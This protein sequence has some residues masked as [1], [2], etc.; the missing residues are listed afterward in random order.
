M[1]AE[2][3]E[4]LKNLP[5]SPGV[6]LMKDKSGDIIYVG[7][8]KSL[9]SR[10][11]SYFR[12]GNHTYKTSIM[13]EYINDFEYIVTD[14]EVEAYILE[15]NLIK[16]YSP[17]FNIRLKD[18]KSYP[19]IKIT[20]N[21]DFP[22]IF[23]SR[24][25]KKDG[26]KYFGPYADVDA[27]YKSI[28]I[29]KDIFKLRTCKKEIIAGKPEARPCLNFY[30]D[31]C[32][33]PCIGAISQG[34]YQK[35]VDLIAD[36]LA[37]QQD[38]LLKMVEKKMEQA[39]DQRDFEKAAFYRDGKR[40]LGEISSQQKII[41]GDES[42][43]DVIAVA[44]KPD[45]EIACA[46]VLIIR[47]GRLIGQDYIILEGG[48]NN[49]LPELIGSFILQ[50]Y[51]QT[52]DIPD[53]I[54]T[55]V[56]PDD[57]EKISKVLNEQKGLK[58][59]IKEPIRGQKKR[60]IELAQKNA[61]QNLARNAIKRRYQNER[62]AREHTELQEYLEL[63]NRPTYIEGFDISNIQGTDTVASLVV[64]KDGH[65]AKDQYRRFKI[66]TVEGAD[67]YASMK[68]VVRRR[69]KR[70]LKENNP[71]PDLVLIDGGKGQLNAAVEELD[72]LGLAQLD[73]IGLAKK[74]EEIF[75]PNKENPVMM[76]ADSPGLHLIQRV[77]DEAHRFAVNYHRKLRSRRLTHSMLDQ[78]PG[79][80]PVR[81]KNLLEHFGSLAK[82]RSADK[83]ELQ[84][85]SGI[86]AATAE[87]I[88]S[89]L[90]EHVTSG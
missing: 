33:G 43:R 51:S 58:V 23:K 62:L 32:S 2:L 84:E 90:K 10:V 53:E 67:D 5:D 1:R 66:K 26:N 17:K 64:F 71:L 54:L 14:T 50:Y 45:S 73:I 69:Y 77:R 68:E 25:L 46:Q 80:G 28:D 6:Y 13:I 19:Y 41:S 16:K 57:K 8:A 31:K 38:D 81:R 40:A 79:V 86:S 30:I 75:L 59:Y 9:R 70:I 48:G 82:I 85:V 34:E 89:Y 4:Q 83:A 3:E 56:R 35:N 63:E 49:S 29:V 88:Y 21:D 42:N 36:F 7:K 74:E 76:P 65:P 15:A 60:L 39:A 47:H 55:E 44:T 37:G 22:R 78:I 24:I 12:K 20:I 72:K 18:D 27:I 61:A 11:R 52:E 87:K